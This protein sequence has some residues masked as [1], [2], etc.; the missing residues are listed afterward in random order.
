M[1]GMSYG[2]YDG[3]TVRYRLPAQ[4]EALTHRLRSVIQ[5]GQN[6]GM[7]VYHIFS[8]LRKRS[9]LAPLSVSSVAAVNGLKK[10]GV[11]PGQIEPD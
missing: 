5:S 3:R 1:I 10:G 6:M 9:K 11:A 8:H 4:V 2:D 7:Q